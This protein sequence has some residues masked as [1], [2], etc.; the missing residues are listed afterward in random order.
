[1]SEVKRRAQSKD[2]PLIGTIPTPKD[3][4]RYV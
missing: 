3:E 4:A 1:M 2:L